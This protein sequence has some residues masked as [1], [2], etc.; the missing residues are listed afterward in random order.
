MR[1]WKRKLRFAVFVQSA[2]ILA[3]CCGVDDPAHSGPRPRASTEGA[4]HSE[5]SVSSGQK[6]NTVNVGLV[7]WRDIP[8]QSV[9]RQAYDYSCGSAAVATLMTYAYNMPRSEKAVF[10]DMFDLGNQEK[11]RREGF[12]MLDMSRYMNTQG[13]KAKGYRIT[14]ESIERNKVPF[15]ALVNNNGYNHF[16]VVK[17]VTPSHVLVGDPNNGNIDY[18]RRDFE[19]IWN[20]LALVVLNRAGKAHA[21]FEDPKEWRFVRAHAPIRN[22]ND[23]GTEMTELNPMSWQIAPTTSDILPAAMA[24]LIATTTVETGS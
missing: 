2:V 18:T 20:G 7:S 12:S 22:G 5:V 21:S 6:G 16:V 3:G 23:A 8:F 11:I 1:A 15:V 17:T 19:K 24:G 4:V 9:E 13:L 10:K 14:L